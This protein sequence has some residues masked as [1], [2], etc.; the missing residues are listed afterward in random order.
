MTVDWE[1][2]ETTIQDR[3]DIV[4][5]ATYETHVP[6]PVVIIEPMSVSLN[7][8]KTG[9]V[10]NGEFTMTNYGLV[11]ADGL[12]LSLPTDDANFKYEFLA[13]VPKSID[14]MERVTVGHCILSDQRNAF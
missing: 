11:R 8:M 2:T 5:H 7:Y 9:D 3:Y 12:H 13:N 14:A 10:L 6:A 1:V 4:L